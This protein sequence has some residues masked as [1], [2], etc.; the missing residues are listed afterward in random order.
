MGTKKIIEEQPTRRL[1]RMSAVADAYDISERTVRSWVADGTLTGYRI[2]QRA[3]RV[4][5]NEVEALVVRRVPT[6]RRAG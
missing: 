6:A 4:D 1:V 5:L 3:L 2:G